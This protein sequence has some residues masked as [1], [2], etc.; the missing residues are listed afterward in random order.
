MHAFFAAHLDREPLPVDAFA[1]DAALLLDVIEHLPDPEAFLVGLRN[2][3]RSLT[4]AGPRPALLLSTPNVAF[5]TMRISLLLGSFNYAERGILDIDHKRLFTKRSLLRALRDCGYDVER[6]VPVGV[7][8]AAVLR[9]PLGRFLGRVANGLAYV[10]PSMF[11]FQFL[12][13]ARPHPGLASLLR[14]SA[15]ADRPGAES[16]A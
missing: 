16:A 12:V 5:V 14:E 3:S 8:F 10:W 15:A 2:R 1:Y 7:P 13:V 9:S 6:V 11:A 4:A